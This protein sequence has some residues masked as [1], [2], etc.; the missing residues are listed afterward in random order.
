M[1]DETPSVG[2]RNLLMRG[3]GAGAGLALAAVAFGASAQSTPT[4]S[5]GRL[6]QA[7]KDVRDAYDKTKQDIDDFGGKVTDPTKSTYDGIKTAFDDLGT[8]LDD[9]EKLPAD[10]A[11]DVKRAYRDIQ[12]G[13]DDLDLKIDELESATDKDAKTGWD[14]VRKSVRDVHHQVDYVFDSF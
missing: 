13:L 8:K 10:S 6:E 12:H 4:T 2:R 5:S 14:A 7:R 1:T 3:A 9:A 11:H